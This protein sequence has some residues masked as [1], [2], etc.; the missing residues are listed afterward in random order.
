MKFEIKGV[1]YQ[2]LKEH[3]DDLVIGHDLR[4]Y[5]LKKVYGLIPGYWLHLTVNKR[6]WLKTWKDTGNDVKDTKECIEKSFKEK[7]HG[8]G[9]NQAE[10]KML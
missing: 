10:V 7:L 2:D 5:H 1:E 4:T 6:S 8:I 9:L 3:L